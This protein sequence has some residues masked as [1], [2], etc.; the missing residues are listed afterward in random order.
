MFEANTPPIEKQACVDCPL[1]ID[2]Q[3]TQESKLQA[4]ITL[5]SKALQAFYAGWWLNE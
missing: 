3:I 4:I 1:S 5:A 2:A